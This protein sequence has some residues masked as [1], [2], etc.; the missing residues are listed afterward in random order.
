MACLVGICGSAAF[1]RIEK[2]HE[3]AMGH[4][5]GREELG[6]EERGNLCGDIII[7]ITKIKKFSI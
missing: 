3:W 7:K 5:G 1:L 2:G 4:E 6:R